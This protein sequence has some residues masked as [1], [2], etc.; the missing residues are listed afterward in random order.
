MYTSVHILS[1]GIKTCTPYPI[2]LL[3]RVRINESRV[4]TGVGSRSH[5]KRKKKLIGRKTRWNVLVKFVFLTILRARINRLV[6]KLKIND[7]RELFNVNR[8]NW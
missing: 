8:E 4:Y 5:S 2:V 1:W 3:I 6:R 7:K